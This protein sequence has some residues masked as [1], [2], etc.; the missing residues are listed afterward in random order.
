MSWRETLTQF[1]A[2]NQA[3][4]FPFTPGPHWQHINR[5][6]REW[7]ETKGIGDIETQIYNSK[8]ATPCAYPPHT[9]LKFM[10][11]ENW[12]E[13]MPPNLSELGFACVLLYQQLRERDRLGIL[14]TV[15][16]AASRDS[17]VVF[18]VNDILIS[19]DLLLSVET[20]YTIDEICPLFEGGTLRIADLGAGWG[21][22]GHALLNF[23]R[24]KHLHYSIFDL[25]E[26]R[27]LSTL[28]LP[29]VIPKSSNYDILDSGFLR[30]VPNKSIDVLISIASFQEMTEEQR[31]AYYSLISE[32][33]KYLYSVQKGDVYTMYPGKIVLSRHPLWSNVCH[34]VICEL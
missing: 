27:L 29:T 12:K 19:W 31:L 21:R 3:A 1:T 30:R 32:K 5:L 11:G 7:M 23:V 13:F 25:P 16:P 8:F 28:Y 17:D 9:Y 26:S 34:E 18:E 33:A 6:F 14:G 4:G 2:E 22:I 24:N 10:A 20:L 15:A